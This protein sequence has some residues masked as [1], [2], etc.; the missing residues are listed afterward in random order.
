[1]NELN[2]GIKQQKNIFAK[3]LGSFLKKIKAIKIKKP[4]KRKDLLGP[5]LLP[6]KNEYIYHNYIGLKNYSE[7]HDNDSGQV[8]TKESFMTY[9]GLGLEYGLTSRFSFGI[10]VN[11]Y[12]PLSSKL[13]YGPEAPIGY[14]GVSLK[15]EYEFDHEGPFLSAA[16]KSKQG[17]FRFIFKPEKEKD[18]AA[19]TDFDGKVLQ[20]GSHSLKERYIS[21]GYKKTWKKEEDFYSIH[22]DLQHFGGKEEIVDLPLFSNIIQGPRNTIQ[23]GIEGQRNI[24]KTNA[25]RG[26]LNVEKSTAMNYQTQD[27]KSVIVENLLGFNQKFSFLHQNSSGLWS[28]FFHRNKANGTYGSKGDKVTIRK[29]NLGLGYTKDFSL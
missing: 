5:N 23:V 26:E 28:I 6:G 11:L 19:I 15:E 25:I 8:S 3:K 16:Y 7:G 18:F 20:K 10:L 27:G 29:I 14:E 17:L 1:M 9:L 24:N 2:E 4:K 13:H 22:L 21:L 12:F